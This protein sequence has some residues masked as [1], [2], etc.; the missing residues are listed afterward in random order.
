M[1]R[2]RLRRSMAIA[3]IPM[4][5]L[6]GTACQRASAGQRCTRGAA[7]DGVYVLA[8]VKGRW[9]RWITKAH[10]QRLLDEYRASL[11]PTP[12]PPPPPPTA[13][14]V[15]T[16][17]PPPGP[18]STLTIKLASGCS[19]YGSWTKSGTRLTLGGATPVEGYYLETEQSSGA[20]VDIPV[21]SRFTTFNAAVGLNDTATA[22]IGSVITF[23]GDGRV[24]ATVPVA[25]TRSQPVSLNITGV[26][27]L[28]ISAA[29]TGACYPLASAYAMIVN[30]TVQ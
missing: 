15:T 21:A 20:C 27:R 9:V 30:P 4:L 13:P 7:E 19:D 12:P 6:A 8:C 23:K 29:C 22:G 1:N 11:A 17:P 10:G 26:G 28:V 18:I 2:S 5:A 24:L 14:P 3:L 25:T 16:P